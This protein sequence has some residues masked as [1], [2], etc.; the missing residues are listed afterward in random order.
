MISEEEEEKAADK[1]K[2]EKI[3]ITINLNQ[4]EW[5]DRITTCD[6]TYD[7]VRINAGYRT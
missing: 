7:Y 4:G 6:L 3:T 2:E 1:M 5:K